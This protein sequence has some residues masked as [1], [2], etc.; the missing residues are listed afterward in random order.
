MYGIIN[1]AIQGFFCDRFSEDSWGEIAHTAGDMALCSL[2][3]INL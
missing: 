3:L 1:K 2:L